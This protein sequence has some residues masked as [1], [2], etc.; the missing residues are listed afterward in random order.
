MDERWPG[1]T[2]TPYD[3]HM[4]VTGGDTSRRAYARRTSISRWRNPR[5]VLGA[6]L[7]VVSALAGGRLV[8][9]AR[10]S[11]DYW[12][13]RA[14]V[15]V[16]QPVRASDLAPAAARVEGSASGALVRADGGVPAGVWARDVGAGTLVTSDAV[17]RAVES[18]RQ[19]AAAVPA[20]S[21]PPDLGAGDRVDVWAGPGD[22]G[23]TMVNTRRVLVGVEVVSVSRPDGTGTRTVVLD[24]G[25][26][27]PE[28][29]VVA[30]VAGG[31]LTVVRVP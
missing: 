25:R 11:T 26:A 17:T 29:D 24:T 4:H 6:V 27:G 28:P 22:G 2:A 30:A 20:G 31:R 10:D 12:L 1:R 9:T 7:V 23:V 8:A 3:W 14:D 19:L 21:A 18:G 5:L 16:G 15:S 13:V